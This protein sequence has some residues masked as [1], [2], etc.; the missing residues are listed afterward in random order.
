[1]ALNFPNSPSLNDIH[2][3]NGTRWQWN[4][5][6]WTRVVTTGAQGFQGDAGAQG[7]AGPAGATGAQGANGPTGAQG[8]AGPT[9]AQGDTGAQGG[10]GSTGAQGADGNFG[11]ATFDYTFDTSTTD[12]DPGQGNLRFNN[13][14]LSSASLMYI[15]DEDDNGTNIEAFLRTI[16][17]STS[18]IKGHVRVSNRLNANDFA[19]FTISGTNTEATGYHKVNVSYLSGATSFSAGEDIIVTFA[20]TG[21]KGDAGPTGAQGAQGA[22][23]QNGVLG[24]SGAQGA[25][26]AQ[27]SSFSRTE[28]NFTA[29]AGQTTFSVSYVN[30]DDLD[31]FYNGTRLTPDEYTATNGSS[32][33][34]DT[35]AAAGAI[36]D[37]LYFESAGPQGAQGATGAQGAGGSA[38]GTGP[39]GAQGATG[40][41]GAQGATGPTGAQGQNGVLG[42]DGA[43]GATGATGAQGDAGAAGS[44]GA[45]GAQGTSF[46]R[47]EFNATATA[48]QTTFSVSYTNGDDLD[49]FING[50]RLTPSEYTASNGSTVV[51]DVGATVGDI[52]DILYFESAGPQG[53]Q[54]AAGTGAQGATGPTGAQGATGSTGAQGDTGA[55][56]AQGDAGAT[57]AQGAAGPTGAQGDAGGTGPTGAQGATGSTGAQG[58]DGGAGGTGPTGA[59]GAAGTAG[60]QGDDG[61][62][63][64]TGAQGAAGAQGGAGGSS[65][66]DG[67]WTAAAGVLQNLDTI[68]IS[69]NADFRAIEYTIHIENSSGRQAQKALAMQDGTTA[70]IQEYGIMFDGELIVSIGAS[71]FGGNF[72]L[73]A[74]P[75]TGISG[76]T[77]YRWTSQQTR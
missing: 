20:R 2:T 45:Q 65:G 37:I 44:T 7:D 35:G 25:Q 34:L 75:E 4:G 57:G 16:D 26:G 17:D 62:T 76:L 3:E 64:P 50:I 8:A 48:G 53:A 15:D 73:N 51:L 11:G 72:H 32:V 13:T 77:T 71:V 54:G 59:Q 61:G 38:G 58:A 14:D 6:S 33:V 36:I 43:Q 39:T 70:F 30:G 24:G 9:G 28:S 46:T 42:G 21:T 49:V 63:G 47:S 23:G 52:V 12:A 29:T 1:M 68:S 22:Q 41:T 66:N 69:S 55:T 40:P 18:T 67:S 27:G 60:A 5:S 19:I 31:V 74:T 56:G 10:T